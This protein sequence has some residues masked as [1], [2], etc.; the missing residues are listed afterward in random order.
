VYVQHA[1]KEDLLFTI[2]RAGHEQALD[3]VVAAIARSDD[4]QSQ[5]Y[6]LVERF[7]TW[8]ARHH[9]LARVVQYE[10]GALS[11]D[12]RRQIADIRRKT[13]GLVREVVVAGID[14]GRFRVDAI[15]ITVLAIMSLGIDV[16]R[17]YRDGQSWTP[18]LVGECYAE[19]AMRLVGC[20]PGAP[21][22]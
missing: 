8:H 11:E 9:T 4:P 6:D 5:L 1:S 17:W 13:Q 14:R 3:A 16:A 22:D 21:V 18:T 19:L 12:H 20:S 15:D 7:T 2:S 10:I